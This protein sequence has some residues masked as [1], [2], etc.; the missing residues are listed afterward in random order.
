MT[1]GEYSGLLG[2]FPYA[3]RASDSMLFRSYVLLGGVLALIVGLLFGLALV[4]LTFRTL[5]AGGG[6]FTFSRA[7]LL[8]V[9]LLVVF[10]LVTPVLLVARRHRRAGSDALYDGALAATGYLFGASLYLA[11]VVSIPPTQQE[12]PPAFLAPVVGLLYDLPPA[13]GIGPPL[14]AVLLVVAVH[15]W[16]D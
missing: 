1:D 10:P 7:F 15:R 5:G 8:F 4:V 13:A 6:T 3:F 12:P 2:A 14:A 9:G 16:L 11:L